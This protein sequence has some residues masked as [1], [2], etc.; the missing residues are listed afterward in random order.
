MKT[1]FAAAS[2]SLLTI[3]ALAAQPSA[4]KSLD[5][6]LQC[7]SNG[8]DFITPLRINNDIRTK[9]MRVES[10]SINAYWPAKE[11]ALTA[12]DFPV[13]AVLAYQENDPFFQ[14]GDGE[15]IAEWAYGV[16]VRGA[17]SDVEKQVRQAGSSALVHRAFPFLTAILCKAPD[18]TQPVANKKNNNH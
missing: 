3:F 8:H 18:P 5:E 15:P 2:T 14:R 10:N 7:H 6:A 4:A 1:I 12:F 9:P 13:F 17:K 16:V 11:A